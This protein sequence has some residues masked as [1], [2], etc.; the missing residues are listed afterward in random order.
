MWQSREL[1]REIKN[2]FVALI[3]SFAKGKVRHHKKQTHCLALA[4]IGGQDTLNYMDVS[5]RGDGAEEA[6]LFACTA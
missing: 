1:R 6:T 4:Q 2:E 3:L 5:G